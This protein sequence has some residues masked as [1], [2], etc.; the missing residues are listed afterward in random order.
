[1]VTLTAGRARAVVD[2][3]RGGRLASLSIDGVEILVGADADPMRWGSYPMVPFAGRIAHGRFTFD[4]ID[5][6]LP[7]NLGPHAIHGYGLADPWNRLGQSADPDPTEVTL[8]WPF[9]APWPWPGRAEQHFALD[10]AGLTTTLRLTATERQ[11]LMGGWHP[12]FR[13]DVGLG[14]DAEL[15]FGPARMYELDDVAIPTGR[16]VDPPPPP[17]DN[18]FTELATEPVIR[19]GEE[20]EVHLSSSADHWVVFTEPTHALCVEPQTAAPDAVN[21]GQTT[22]AAGET[23]EVWYRLAWDRA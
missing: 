11:P 5:H 8:G 17:W 15:S 12:W 7:T 9:R 20:L 14:A 22:V 21:R 4:G 10:Q 19:W 6:E 16:L 13:R 3:E 1:M 18:C 2:P 23:L